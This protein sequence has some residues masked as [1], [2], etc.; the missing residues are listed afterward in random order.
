MIDD[1][2]LRKRAAKVLGWKYV[3]PPDDGEEYICWF[4]PE[5]LPHS[6]PT[7]AEMVLPTLEWLLQRQRRVVLTKNTGPTQ[8]FV[9]PATGTVHVGG[10]LATAIFRAVDALSGGG[11]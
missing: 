3:E 1:L 10:E 5:G 9:A 11:G 4:T 8:Y 2:D 7:A 6:L